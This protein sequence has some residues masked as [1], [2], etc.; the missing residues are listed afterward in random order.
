[1]PGKL[2]TE[3]VKAI[4][5]TAELTGTELSEAG[6]AAMVQ[7]LAVFDHGQVLGA[8]VR[9]RRE[10]KGKL[11][12]AAVLERLDDGRP[13]PEEAWSMLPKSE[14]DT[15]VWTEEMSQAFGVAQPLLAEGDAIAARMAFREKYAELVMRA[16]NEGKRVRWW[17]TL[18]H[19][20]AGREGPLLD[21]VEKGRM[22]YEAVRPFLPAP[23][24]GARLSEL[25]AQAK[26]REL[27]AAPDKA[28]E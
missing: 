15:S 24:T 27:L 25:K 10:L 28:H 13:G 11:T 20:V 4:A 23:E 12:I 26:K 14:A 3:L 18:G 2:R 9:C 1:M 7:D 6:K 16:R 8:L 22:S 19:S 21:A 17:Q 5:V